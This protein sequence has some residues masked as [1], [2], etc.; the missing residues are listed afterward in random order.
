MVSITLSFS[1]LKTEAQKV[2]NAW[3][4]LRDKEEP[5]IYCGFKSW[6]KG[7]FKAEAAHFIAVSVGESVRYN[8]NNC[9]KAHRGCNQENDSDL[10]RSNLVKKIG[11]D[12]V[13]QLEAQAHSLAKFSRFEI[14]EVYAKYK[15]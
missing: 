5:C 11:E 6:G 4:L 10:Y 3:I 12:A 7:P 15:V 1:A 13:Q 8:E 9:H 2:F 14:E